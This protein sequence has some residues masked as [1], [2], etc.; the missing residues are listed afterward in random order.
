MIAMKRKSIE[1]DGRPAKTYKLGRVCQFCGE[2]IADHERAS[3]THCSRYKDEFGNVHDCKRRKHTLKTQRHEDVL[4]DFSARQ[5]GTKRQIERVIAA[6]GDL[7]TTDVLE[8]YNVNPGDNLRWYYHSG[9]M[10][11]ELLGYRIISNPKLNNHKIEKYG[12]S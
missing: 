7:V 11:A 10:Y 9:L 5:R 8:A 12:N 1:V 2:P 6:H 4:L 3:K